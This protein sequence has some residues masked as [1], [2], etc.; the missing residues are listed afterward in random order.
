[1][2]NDAGD[3][4][5]CLSRIRVGT[6]M[7]RTICPVGAAA[8]TSHW[9]GGVFGV[10]RTSWQPTELLNGFHQHN[11]FTHLAAHLHCSLCCQT[12]ET[13]AIAPRAQHCSTK[14]PL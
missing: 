14:N 13:Y 9:G 7:Y 2:A 12:M 1:M 10:M 8:E 11:G 3:G 6:K 4:E 5:Y